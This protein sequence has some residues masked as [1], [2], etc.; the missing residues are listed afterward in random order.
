MRTTI[1]LLSTGE[2]TLLARS[3]PRALAQEP[4]PEV[5]VVDNGSTDETA[6]IAE[7]HGAVYLRL[8][9]R[10]TYA[11]AI[12]VALARTEGEAVVLLNADCFLRPGFLAASLPHRAFQH[13]IDFVQQEIRSQKTAFSS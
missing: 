4:R 9:P 10:R 13:E 2:S 1:I 3:L 6:A 5:V 8:E 7:R 11:A 12:N